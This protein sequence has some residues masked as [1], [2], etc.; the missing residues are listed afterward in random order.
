MGTHC[1]IT[2]KHKDGGYYSV[3]CHFDGFV[4]DGVGEILAKHYNNQEA[5]EDLLTYGDISSLDI[6]PND[7][8]SKFY[9][10]D[11]DEDFHIQ[12]GSYFRQAVDGNRQEHNYLWE[13][14]VW[15]YLPRALTR[16]PLSELIDKIK[17]GFEE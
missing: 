2:A 6:T 5:I 17:N 16:T 1:S 10:R 8:H 3:F 12:I 4:K 13:D 15:Y 9:K 11:Y 14:G 7:Y